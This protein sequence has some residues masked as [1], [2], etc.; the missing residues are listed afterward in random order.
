MAQPAGG[1]GLSLHWGGLMPAFAVLGHAALA[2]LGVAVAALVVSR[3][4]AT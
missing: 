4:A 3:R 2:G 1:D